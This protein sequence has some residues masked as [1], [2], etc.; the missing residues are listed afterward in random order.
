MQALG[1][2]AL[3]VG[4]FVVLPWGLALLITGVLVLCGGVGVEVAAT[5]TAGRAQLVERLRSGR[6]MVVPDPETDRE[7]TAS[8]R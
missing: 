7:R 3:A 6:V 2:V 5:R 8:G 1:A 4:L